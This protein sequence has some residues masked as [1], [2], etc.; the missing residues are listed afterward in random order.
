MSPG[1]NFDRRS[2]KKPET[3][4]DRVVVRFLTGKTLEGRLLTFDSDNGILKIGVAEKEFEVDCSEL[5]AI[6]FLRRSGT[7]PLSEK[8]LKPGGK[9]IRVAFQDG[10]EIIGYSYALQPHRLGF[11]L[12]PIHQEDRNEKVYVIRKNAVRIQTQ[13]E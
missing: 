11:F 6:F 9:R 3:L 1:G 8:G 2:K 5:K 10:E 4:S 13:D 7:T 12:F